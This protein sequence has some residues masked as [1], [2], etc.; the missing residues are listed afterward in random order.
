MEKAIHGRIPLY[1]SRRGTGLGG[2]PCGRAPTGGLASHRR[3]A[4]HS[5]NRPLGSLGPIHRQGSSEV[6]LFLLQGFPSGCFLTPATTW[7]DTTAADAAQNA[8]G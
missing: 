5:V 2:S 7:H 1:A 4:S 8:C 6:L 3:L